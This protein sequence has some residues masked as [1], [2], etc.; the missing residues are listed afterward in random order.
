[1]ETKE[2]SETLENPPAEVTPEEFAPVPLPATNSPLARIFEKA[3]DEGDL[4]K[5][6]EVANML[7]SSNLVPKAYQGKPGDVIVAY[8]LGNAVG[9]PIL[10]ALQ[11]IA[12]INGK[13]CIYGDGLIAIVKANGGKLVETRMFN[14]AGELTGYQCTA[15]RPG[16]PDV[17]HQFTIEDAKNAQLLNKQ[18]PWQQYKP[19]ML[20]MRARGFAC[21]D[22]YADW[23]NGMILREEA[24]DY[25][26]VDYQTGEVL[27]KMG[28]RKEFGTRTDEIINQFS[29]GGEN[30]EESPQE[31]VAEQSGEAGQAFDVAKAMTLYELANTEEDMK[32]LNADVY[33]P[34]INSLS[35]S[36]KKRL[37]DALSDAWKRIR[38]N[39]G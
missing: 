3:S 23:L 1:M 18:G 21:R 22:Q 34:N 30:K 38:S 2:Q 24:E 7:A 25:I 5:M 27:K 33:Q 8:E 13:P 15:M 12:V 20:Q 36:D 4:Q 6:Q 10:P 16:H 11:N 19:R 31:P 28:D 9:L 26:D 39:G 17:T 29:G 35:K 14:D 37:D 32:K